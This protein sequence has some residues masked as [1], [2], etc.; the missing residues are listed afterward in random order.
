MDYIF[1]P[2][3]PAILQSKV[4]V[5]VHLFQQQQQIKRQLNELHQKDMALYQSQKLEAVGRL[6]GGVA[7]DFNNLIMGVLGLSHDLSTTL[8]S[9]DPRQDDLHEIIKA[10]NRAL[11]LTKQLLAFGRRQITSPR[12]R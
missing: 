1:K 9:K 5:F 11:A 7:H 3:D 12:T 10:S 4:A 6:A 2:F 8:D